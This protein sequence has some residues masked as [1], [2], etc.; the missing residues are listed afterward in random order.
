MSREQSVLRLADDFMQALEDCNV[1]AV[2]GIY[3]ED[4]RLWHNFDGKLQSVEDNI[5]TLKWLHSKLKKVEYQIVRR[6]LLFDGFLQEHVLRGVL[7]S[8]EAFAMPACAIIKV[9]GNKIISLDEYLDAS[10][11]KPLF[12]A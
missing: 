8:G 4:A 11:V 7:D 9:Q 6:E 5:K 12:S 3:C 10:H 2:R 1:D